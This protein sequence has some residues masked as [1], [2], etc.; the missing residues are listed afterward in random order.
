MN[1]G[2]VDSGFIVSSMCA[3]SA[4]VVRE[5][6]DQA[7]SGYHMEFSQNATDVWRISDM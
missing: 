4:L 7:L 6:P 5:N 1:V 2:E 3:F